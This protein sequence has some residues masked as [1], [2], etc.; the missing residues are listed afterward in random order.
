MKLL[1]PLIIMQ[2]YNPPFWFKNAQG[3]GVVVHSYKGDMQLKIKCGGNG[4]LEI[5]LRGMDCRDKNNK[6]FPVWIDYKKLK[7]RGTDIFASSHVVWHDKPF[8]CR[9]NVA[10]GEMVTIDVEWKAVDNTS[11]YLP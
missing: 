1:S 7:V 3:Q 8:K 9:L 10:D 2:I 6:R 11:E 4:A 5:A